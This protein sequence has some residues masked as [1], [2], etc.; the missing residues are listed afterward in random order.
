LTPSLGLRGGLRRLATGLIAYGVV[1]LAVA[2]LGLVALGWTGGRVAGLA[3]TVDAE[4]TQLVLTLD[5]TADALR[6]AGTSATAFA[7]TL[8]RTPPSV[9][10]AAQTIRDLQPS[11]ETIGIQ[12]DSI[13]ILGTQPLAGPAQLFSAMAA[14]LEGLDARLD[15]I[16]DD[17]ETDRDVLIV[18]ADSLRDLGDR[19]AILA[20]RVRTGFIQGGLDDLRAVLILTILV[21]VGWTA[22]PAVGALAFGLWLHRTLERAED[23]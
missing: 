22:V 4:A 16:A 18:N 2:L 13:S 12:L 1:G 15:L 19:T 8:D 6:D 21:F 5:R 23:A 10:Q 7:T 9:R 14:D 3:D 11:L 17:L 20:E